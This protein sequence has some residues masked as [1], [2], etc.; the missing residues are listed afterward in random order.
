VVDATTWPAICRIRIGGRGVVNAFEVV[1]I[2]RSSFF[3]GVQGSQE[4]EEEAVR[5]RTFKCP[6]LAGI[7]PQIRFLDHGAHLQTVCI[8]DEPVIS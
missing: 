7:V 4:T 2:S 6:R 5:F 3:Y 8:L 1:S